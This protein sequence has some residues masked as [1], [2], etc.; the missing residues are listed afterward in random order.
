MKFCKDCK[1]IAGVQGDNYE[2]AHCE[3]PQNLTRDPV[4]GGMVAKHYTYCSIV[5]KEGVGRCGPDAAW[6]EPREDSSSL[7]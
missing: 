2:F 7:G 5:R 1:H 4:A 3:A 6:F